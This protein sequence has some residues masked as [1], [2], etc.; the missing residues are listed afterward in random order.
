MEEKLIILAQ[1]VLKEINKNERIDNEDL[2]EISLNGN[3]LT[4]NWNS[5]GY[6]F[7]LSSNGNWSWEDRDFYKN[8][9][10]KSMKDKGWIA[11]L[12]ERDFSKEDAFD[13]VNS[14]VYIIK[15]M[16]YCNKSNLLSEE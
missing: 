11:H 3:I 6:N 10:V 2:V 14:W 12:E 9:K 7:F 8:G 1:E 13:A 16:K 4:A 15:K 5:F